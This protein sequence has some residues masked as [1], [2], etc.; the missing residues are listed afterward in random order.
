MIGYR[1][2]LAIVFIP[3][4]VATLFFGAYFE[5]WSFS[6]LRGY[7]VSGLI[8]GIPQAL[9]FIRP[10]S[11]TVELK[12]G[13]PIMSKFDDERGG[14][15]HNYFTYYLPVEN[16]GKN[17][18]ARDCVCSISMG[19]SELKNEYYAIWDKDGNSRSLN[20][21]HFEYLKLFMVIEF[22]KDNQNEKWSG[23]LFLGTLSP[24]F[25]GYS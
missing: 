23:P 20:I 24:L 1:K 17:T 2:L 6:E 18:V 15:I 12:F 7:I 14:G 8:G 25:H 11:N 9:R 21:G 19:D 10:D 22:H 5:L 13:E 3:I 4:A 16:V